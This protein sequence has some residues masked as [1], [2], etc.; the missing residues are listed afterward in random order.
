MADTPEAIAK[1]FKAIG[2]NLSR[3]EITA[4]ARAALREIGQ[5]R[6]QL[7][8]DTELVQACVERFGGIPASELAADAEDAGLSE[9]QKAAINTLLD[10][11]LAVQPETTVAEM[12]ELVQSKRAIDL[13]D[14]VEKPQAVMGSM[15]FQAKRRLKPNGTATTAPAAPATPV[16]AAQPVPAAA[17]PS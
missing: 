2:E 8:K 15:I 3:E 16:I 14:L 1:L 9:A 13:A 10:E 6:A 7:R 4:A 17:V 5:Q 11:T 12:I